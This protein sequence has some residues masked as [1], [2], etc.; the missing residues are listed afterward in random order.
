MKLKK[1]PRKRGY[2]ALKTHYN[3]RHQFHFES[4][5]KHPKELSTLLKVQ[6]MKKQ[7]TAIVT[8][9]FRACKISWERKKS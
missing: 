3:R 5:N 1:K 2:G 7:A 9:T 8:A 4:R 6:A